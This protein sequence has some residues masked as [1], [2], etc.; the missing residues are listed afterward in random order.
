M[1][2]WEKATAVLIQGHEEQNLQKNRIWFQG[3]RPCLE[4]QIERGSGRSTPI[5]KVA[6]GVRMRTE[7][8]S[9]AG[10][11]VISLVTIGYHWLL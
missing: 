1:P 5:V 4:I 7:I 11:L 9:C 3:N 8:F 6:V 10:R 2:S